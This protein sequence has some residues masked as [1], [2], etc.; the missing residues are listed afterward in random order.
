MV[1]GINP[2]GM[3]SWICTMPSIYSYIYVKLVL[4]VTMTLSACHMV[5]LRMYVCVCVLE[6]GGGCG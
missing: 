6:R 5:G 1:I 4:G 2:F 3:G